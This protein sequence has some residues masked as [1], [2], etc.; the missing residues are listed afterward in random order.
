MN[1]VSGLL[2]ARDFDGDLTSKA[3]L[4]GTVDLTHPS[5]P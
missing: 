5:K 3:A 2:G 4:D 1:D